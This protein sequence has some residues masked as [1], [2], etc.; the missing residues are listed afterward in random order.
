MREQ[1]LGLRFCF[2][3]Y[4]EYEEEDDG[5]VMAAKHSESRKS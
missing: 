4:D 5:V 2:I 1:F 3:S